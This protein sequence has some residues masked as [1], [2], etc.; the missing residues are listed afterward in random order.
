LP[1]DESIKIKKNHLD[2]RLDFIRCAHNEKK[3]NEIRTDR[4][5]DYLE[6][7]YELIQQ[8]G[9]ATTAD[10]SKYLNVSSPSV[11]KMVKKLDENRYLIYE[12]Y[13]GLSLT[14]EG[15]NIAKNMHEKHSLFVEFLKMIG[16][17]DETAHVDAEGIEHHLHP[18][19]IKKLE[20]FIIL[21]KKRDPKLIEDLQQKDIKEK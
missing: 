15:I 17:D 8:K 19:T 14:N 1:I 7:I 2:K 16:I 11:T 20:S 5:E 21:L 18:Q 13:R 4:M 3:E 9:Y 12:K 6:V 10:I